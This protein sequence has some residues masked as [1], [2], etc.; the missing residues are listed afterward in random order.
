MNESITLVFNILD[1]N[2]LPVPV[3]PVVV[4]MLLD[5]FYCVEKDVSTE[6]LKEESFAYMDEIREIIFN[7]SLEIDNY[8]SMYGLVA[9]TALSAE[10]LFRIKRDYAICYSIYNLGNRIYLDYLKSS[11]KEKFLGDVKIA[12]Q[13]ENDPSAIKDKSMA[14]KDCM[15]T[16]KGL[17]ST[18]NDA[19]VMMNIFVKGELNSSSKTSDR[20]WWWNRPYANLVPSPM[21]GTKYRNPAT[22]TLQKIG[23]VN[24][25]YYDQF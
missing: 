2:N 6:F 15:E 23:S 17:F 13:F 10:Q 11:K 25:S 4:N 18:W 24:I 1:G 20:E 9:T 12:L 21:G 3:D 5:P 16:I 7:A 14:A 8:I 22:N 19:S